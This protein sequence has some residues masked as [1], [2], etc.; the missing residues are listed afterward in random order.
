MLLSVSPFFNFISINGG[1]LFNETFH[2]HYQVHHVTMKRHTVYVVWRKTQI[3]LC[4]E[5]G[6]VRQNPIHRTNNCL[7]KCLWLC[8][9]SVQHTAQN[10]S[11]NLSF[12][13]QT[14]IIAQMS[15]GGKMCNCRVT[16]MPLDKNEKGYYKTALNKCHCLLVYS[17]DLMSSW[18]HNKNV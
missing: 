9:N 8:T 10:S 16:F 7:S 4:S 3:N 6:S 2:N 13:F 18:Q 12:Y 11:D 1:I 15:L 14:T 5:M 17:R